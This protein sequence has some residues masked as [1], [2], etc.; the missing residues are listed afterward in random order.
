MTPSYEEVLAKINQLNEREARLRQEIE[1]IRREREALKS[2]ID[3]KHE[4]IK[5]PEWVD[6]MPKEFWL[7]SYYTHKILSNTKPCK[8]T[9]PNLTPDLSD[10]HRKGSFMDALINLGIA[11][12][13]AYVAIQIIFVVLL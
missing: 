13:I 5:R 3:L 7:P 11:V 12:S 9:D 2:R 1:D 4:G 10:W 8:E 6:N